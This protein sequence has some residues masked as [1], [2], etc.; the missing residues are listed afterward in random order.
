MR[1]STDAKTPRAKPPS[2]AP[3]TQS[4]LADDAYESRTATRVSCSSRTLRG[5]GAVFAE[6][7]PE[8]AGRATK[9]LR[10]KE[11]DGRHGER[12]RDGVSLGL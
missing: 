6:H 11:D 5:T 2:R 9:V 10:R 4:S 1:S 12:G 8:R 7:G 3:H